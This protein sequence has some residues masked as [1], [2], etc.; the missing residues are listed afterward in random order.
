MVTSWTRQVRSSSSIRNVDRS[1]MPGRSSGGKKLRV[2][3]NIGEQTA[4]KV[5]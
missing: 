1:T 2:K 4:V 3:T 5:M